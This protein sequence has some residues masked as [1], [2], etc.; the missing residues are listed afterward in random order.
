MRILLT[1]F[2]LKASKNFFFT[3]IVKHGWFSSL[4]ITPLLYIPSIKILILLF[5][6]P[7]ITGDFILTRL[8]FSGIFLPSV[9]VFYMWNVIFFLYNLVIIPLII[10]FEIS[11]ICCVVLIFL[12]LVRKIGRKK[13]IIGP[14]NGKPLTY[15]FFAFATMLS[16]FILLTWHLTYGISLLGFMKQKTLTFSTSKLFALT[17][18]NLWIN[19]R[20]ILFPVKFSNYKLCIFNKSLFSCISKKFLL[21]ILI[22]PISR[23]LIVI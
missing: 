18:T 6:S 12:E 22:S 16:K 5:L 10:L 19:P 17:F 3:K 23:W 7:P 14:L 9:P 21:P 15:I 20:R 11:L 8:T 2:S 13:S 4:F 1:I